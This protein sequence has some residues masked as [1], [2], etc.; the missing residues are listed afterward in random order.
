M[1]HA[2]RRV[3]GGGAVGASELGTQEVLT[4]ATLRPYAIID[5]WAKSFLPVQWV[6]EQ[7]WPG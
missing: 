4:G 1:A 3:A 7:E 2:T 6:G 5:V